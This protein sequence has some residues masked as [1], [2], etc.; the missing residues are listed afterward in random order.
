MTRLLVKLLCVALLGAVAVAQQGIASPE[1]PPPPLRFRYWRARRRA[2]ESERGVGR[3][4][5]SVGDSRE[6]RD[7]R[8]H[9]QVDRRRQGRR[10]TDAD[11]EDSL[12]H[13]SAL[14]A[15]RLELLPLLDVLV[16]VLPCDVSKPESMMGLGASCPP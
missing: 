9:L 8:R 14:L 2:V 11:R 5:R 3:Y 7:G 4:R 15:T 13:D 10:D 12:S 16:D 6:R 1:Q